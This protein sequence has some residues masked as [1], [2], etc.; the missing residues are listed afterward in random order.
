MEKIKLFLSKY[1]EDQIRKAKVYSIMGIVIIGLSL[2]VYFFLFNDDEKDTVTE[3]GIP[4]AKQVKEYESKIEAITRGNAVTYEDD[5]NKYFEN[6]DLSKVNPFVEP[7]KKETIYQ[8]EDKKIDSL[9][10]V[11]EAQNRTVQSSNTT[12]VSSS[13]KTSSN[14]SNTIQSNP[15]S[16]N[17]VQSNITNKEVKE[18]TE[19]VLTEKEKR[20]LARE[21]RRKEL[22][23]GD[24]KKA[25]NLPKSFSA[26]IRGTQTL[27]SGQLLTLVT[28][29]EFVINNVTIPKN[30][31]LYGAV[32]FSNNKAEVSIT[33][34]NLNGQVIPSNLIVY[35]ANGTKGIDID[36][37]ANISKGRNS[38]VSQG[39]SE[40]SGNYGRAVGIV[41]EVI[42]GKAQE[43][44]VT[45]TDNQKV[46]IVSNER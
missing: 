36:I 42:K 28:N 6:R 23:Q 1:N 18:S 27:R 45:F 39:A 11:F 24:N 22:A 8:N 26:S 25:S 15:T 19:K 37:D 40:I 17:I 12:K 31:N 4:Q 3:I 10:Q 20:E 30:T 35:S 13:N 5:I 21:Q 9:M 2:S 46:L 33:S 38:A 44:K 29:A 14:Q 32:S 7:E 43:V 41:T 34:I 16:N